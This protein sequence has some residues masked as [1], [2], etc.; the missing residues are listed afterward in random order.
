[1][2]LVALENH[3][4][5]FQNYLKAGKKHSFVEAVTTETIAPLIYLFL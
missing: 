4:L 5:R 1:M 3:F 2:E